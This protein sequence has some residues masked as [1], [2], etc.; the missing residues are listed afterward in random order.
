MPEG[1]GVGIKVR[2]HVRNQST[3]TQKNK[4]KSIQV[5]KQEKHG[6][7][8]TNNSVRTTPKVEISPERKSISH[9]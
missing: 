9:Q 8:N 2:N 7:L 5:S 6:Q 4:I 1:N 3:I